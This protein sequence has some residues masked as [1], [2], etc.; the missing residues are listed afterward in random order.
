MLPFLQGINA[1]NQ[2]ILNIYKNIIV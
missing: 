2:Y 1:K